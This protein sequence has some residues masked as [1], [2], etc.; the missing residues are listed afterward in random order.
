MNGRQY[1]SETTPLLSS[2]NDVAHHQNNSL[3]ELEGPSDPLNPVNTPQWRKW[4]Y[5]ANLGAMT[6]A[7]TF[8]SAVFAA[9]TTD[10]AREFEVAPSTVTW[11]TTLFVFGF[12]AGPVIMGPASELYGRKMPLLLGYLC[13]VLF[14]IPVARAHSIDTILIWRF[15]AGVAAAGS[16]A[17]VPGYLADFLTPVERGIAVAIFAATTLAG[18]SAGVIV[19][20][21]LLESSLGWRWSVWVSMII[22]GVFGIVGW[23]TVP[24]TYV[25]VLLKRK[26]SRLR[27]ETKDWALHS[28]LDEESIDAKKFAVRYLSRPFMMLGQEPILALMTLYI[29]F[30]F[31]MVYFLFTVSFALPPVTKASIL[32]T[33]RPTPSA[34]T[35]S[36]ASSPCAALCPTSPSSRA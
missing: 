6:F 24:E 10:V 4:L 15:L 33:T 32:T 30:T 9:C 26:A 36:E 14:Q 8:S 18:P 11:A 13:F 35:A 5:A 22:G 1:N 3:V 2:H 21:L 25:P 7:V 16:P 20:S 27:L 31:G 19:G 34:S 29:S 12:A 23:L 28:K 17:I